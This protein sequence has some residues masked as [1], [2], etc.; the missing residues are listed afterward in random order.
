[1]SVKY[2]SLKL[3]SAVFWLQTQ[4]PSSSFWRSP[5]TPETGRDKQTENR[6]CAWK[7][8]SFMWQILMIVV[9]QAWE[10]VWCQLQQSSPDQTPRAFRQTESISF[11]TFISPSLHTELKSSVVYVCHK[12]TSLSEC[13][14][15]STSSS[16]MSSAVTSEGSCCFCWRL[17]SWLISAI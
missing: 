4:H 12:L 13:L 15:C 9:L 17:R 7:K 8:L 3:S 16:I 6:I 14:L 2:N 10:R 5:P 1:M 11:T